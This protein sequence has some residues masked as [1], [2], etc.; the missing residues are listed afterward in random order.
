M[1]TVAY[2]GAWL[3]RSAWSDDAAWDRLTEWLEEHCKGADIP[4]IVTPHLDSISRPAGLVRIVESAERQNEHGQ[5]PGRKWRAGDGPIII[6]W[7]KET[8]VQAKVTQVSGL[9][10]QSIILLEEETGDTRLKN[11]QGWA[12]AVGAFNAATGKEEKTH[13]ELPELLDSIL[14]NYENELHLSPGSAA[15][16]YGASATVLRNKFK[17][18]ATNGY[19][20]DFVVTYAI[21]MGY[22]GPLHR[23][24]EHFSAA[25]N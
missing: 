9:A 5:G 11:F 10:N 7:P 19:D 4:V 22:Q 1:Y 20:A 15:A 18:L 14:A 16:S 24:R 6:V 8:T 12:A 23:L 17:A 21:A 3:P 25:A 13:P 2:S